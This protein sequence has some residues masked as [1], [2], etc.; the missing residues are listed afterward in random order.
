MH[1]VRDGR[2]ELSFAA[3]LDAE[4][5]RRELHWSDLWR[6][7]ESSLYAERVANYMETFGRR[8]VR[9]YF[10]DDLAVRPDEML[11]DLFGFLEVDPAVRCDTSRAYNRT[12]V[13]RSRALATFLTR[14]SSLKSALKGVVPERIRVGL[15]ERVLSWNTGAKPEIEADVRR[16]LEQ[17]FRR[18]T[19]RLAELLE[20]PLPWGG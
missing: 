20:R 1:L 9:V 11:R 14:P 8:N 16:R 7:A 2:E 17:Y 12:G 13:S 3:A 15:R 6:Y 10:F 4:P 5:R 19:I 18:D